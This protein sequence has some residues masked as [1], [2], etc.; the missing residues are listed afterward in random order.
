MMVKPEY[1]GS[2]RIFE[3]S[4][5]D[6]DYIDLVVPGHLTVEKDGAGTFRFGVVEAELDCRVELFGGLERLEFTF[7]GW[8]EG[9]E[10]FGRGWA[11]LEGDMMNGW[12]CFHE[13][14][15]STFKAERRA[16]KPDKF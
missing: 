4:E 14:D 12:F 1:R 16:V 3:M 10:V 8:A 13:G 7:F 5:W 6:S 9:D 11:S 15:E 2:W